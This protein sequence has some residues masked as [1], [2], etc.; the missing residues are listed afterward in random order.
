MQCIAFVK[1]YFDLNTVLWTSVTV[2]ESEMITC[3]IRTLVISELTEILTKKNCF[4]V[5]WGNLA[6]RSFVSPL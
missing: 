3:D 5:R 6:I 2:S 1:R 4:K